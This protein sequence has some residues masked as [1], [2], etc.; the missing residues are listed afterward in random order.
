MQL[1]IKKSRERE[2]AKLKNAKQNKEEI[3]TKSITKKYKE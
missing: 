3:K 2:S 1:D